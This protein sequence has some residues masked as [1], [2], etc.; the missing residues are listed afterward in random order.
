MSPKLLRFFPRVC[1]L[2]E[3]AGIRNDDRR[4]YNVRDRGFQTHD[5]DDLRGAYDDDH[6]RAYGGGPCD[7]YVPHGDDDARDDHAY[8][9]DDEN[10]DD[11]H[12]APPY[13]RAYVHGRA[14]GDGL[15]DDDVYDPR[16]DRVYGYVRDCDDD[17]HDDRDDALRDDR[18]CARVRDD[19]YVPPCVHAC[20]VLCGRV[21]DDGDVSQF[22]YDCDDDDAR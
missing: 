7:V 16:N 6:V 5:D 11:P 19:A 12:D 22:P 13:D 15:R 18:A 10:D 14:Y 1:I 2:H 4:F 3:Q 21:R 8:G 20:D 9:L 17:S